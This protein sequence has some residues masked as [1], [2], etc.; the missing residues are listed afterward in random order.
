MK[1]YKMLAFEI[2]ILLI[3]IGCNPDSSIMQ[4]MP[5]DNITV[6]YDGNNITARYNYGEVNSLANPENKSDGLILK[7][8]NSNNVDK[9]GMSEKWS[10]C[11]S[12]GGIAV[13]Y[14]YQ[15]TKDKVM[16]DSVSAVKKAPPTEL[17][18]N[19]WM[20]S[21]ELLEITE[22][23]G[24]SDFRTK[25]EN[26]KIKMVLEEPLGYMGP[27]YWYVEY[28]SILNSN[29]RLQFIVDASTGKLKL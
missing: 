6:R 22:I 15:A 17:I 23:N 9:N 16:L 25:N 27:T 10:Y 1:K 14:Y 11:Y 8:L 13:T 24:G 5:G 4:S 21:I 19:Y 20:D 2:L 26:Y 7:S 12:S 3:F 29:V 28:Y 18:S